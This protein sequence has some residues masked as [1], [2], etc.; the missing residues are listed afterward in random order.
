MSCTDQEAE[1]NLEQAISTALEYEA[2]VHQTYAEAVAGTDHVVA[3]RVFSTLCDEEL[4]HI[5]YLRERLEEWRSTGTIT[6]A[7]LDTVLVPK[8]AIESR[9]AQLEKTLAGDGKASR[10]TEL[11]SLKKALDVEIQTSNFYKKMVDTLDADG[12]RLF[13]RFVEIEEGHVAIVQAE[14]DMVTGSGFW[15]DTAEFSLEK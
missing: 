3:K 4:E 1:M 15:F 5:K 14:M 11:D 10:G 9:A 6:I 13:E 2:R 12:K 8:E 7:D